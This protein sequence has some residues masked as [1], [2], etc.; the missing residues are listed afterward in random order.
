MLELKQ[1]LNT[2]KDNKYQ[3][4]AI[5]ENAV[6][7]KFAE[8]LLPKLNYLVFWKS[9]SKKKNTHVLA[10]TIIYP[11]MIS[12]TF[13]KDNLEKLIATCLFLNPLLRMTEPTI[14]LKRKYGRGK[15]V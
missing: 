9:Y 14:K 3:V 15:H 1:E 7:T 6:Y 13:Y 5:K 8:E 11:Q 12:N 10:L 4:V 2:R